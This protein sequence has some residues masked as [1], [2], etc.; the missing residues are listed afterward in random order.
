MTPNV[1]MMLGAALWFCAALFGTWSCTA[2]QARQILEPADIVAESLEQTGVGGPIAAAASDQLSVMLWRVREL[3]RK[4]AELVQDGKEP[5]LGWQDWLTI[6]GLSSGGGLTAGG[7]L[8]RKK[9][10]NGTGA[11]T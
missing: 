3:E 6:L 9:N 5:A 10:G 8:A 1:K 2:S 11:G 7:A 4:Q